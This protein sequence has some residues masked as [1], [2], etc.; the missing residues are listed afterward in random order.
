LTLFFPGFRR[1]ILHFIIQFEQK[2]DQI[3]ALPIFLTNKYGMGDPFYCKLICPAGTLEGGFTLLASNEE[4]KNTIGALFFWKL[5]ILVV[6][7]ISCVLFTAHFVSICVLSEQ[8]T[9]Y[10]I[11]LAFIR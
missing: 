7:L 3:L 6:M 1:K 4:L 9:H 11:N 10:L 2:V 8:C 5:G